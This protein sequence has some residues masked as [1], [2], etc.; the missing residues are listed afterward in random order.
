MTCWVHEELQSE[1]KRLVHE[2]VGAYSSG[3][4]SPTVLLYW[5]MIEHH[6]SCDVCR[7]D[8]VTKRMREMLGKP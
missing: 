3:Y 6:T 2:A 7:D 5:R 4:D 1:W 8:E